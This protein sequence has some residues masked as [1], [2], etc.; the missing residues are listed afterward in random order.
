MEV[1]VLPR[2]VIGIIPAGTDVMDNRTEIWTPLGLKPGFRQKARQTR[3][4]AASIHDRRRAALSV[5]ATLGLL[6]AR[7]GVQAIIRLYP[8]SLPRTSE[9]TI[10]RW[11]CASRPACRQSWKARHAQGVC[12]ARVSAPGGRDIRRA[13]EACGSGGKSNG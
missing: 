13:G 11:C 9:V 10:E 12:F 8:T 6:L 5:E 2:E 1:N 4:I 7:G 3:P